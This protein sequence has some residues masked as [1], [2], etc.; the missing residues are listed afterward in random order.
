MITTNLRCSILN[1]ILQFLLKLHIF[2]PELCRTAESI[3]EKVNQQSS[4]LEGYI[5]TL[6]SDQTR[7][8][9]F[10][11]SWYKNKVRKFNSIRKY[12]NPTMAALLRMEMFGNQNYEYRTDEKQVSKELFSLS[13]TIYDYMRNEWRFSLPPKEM[14]EEWNQTESDD[15]IL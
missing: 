8:A 7:L 6:H 9:Y 12:L 2:L 10:N 13:P 1:S 4:Q 15:E 3:L 14:V 5:Q 11:D